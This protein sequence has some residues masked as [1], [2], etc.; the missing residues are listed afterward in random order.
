M[1][2]G[3]LPSSSSSSSAS[4]PSSSSLPS[5][6]LPSFGSPLST[7]PSLADSP[8]A[9]PGSL[10]LEIPQNDLYPHNTSPPQNN[11]NSSQQQQQQQ[12][13]A[14]WRFCRVLI[15]EFTFNDEPYPDPNPP[16]TYPLSTNPSSTTPGTGSSPGTGANEAI[17]LTVVKPIP[18]TGPTPITNP[19]PSSN[20]TPVEASSSSPSRN[21][22]LGSVL[23]S[24]LGQGLGPRSPGA[25]GQGL[26]SPGAQRQGPSSPGAS[27]QGPRS[28]SASGQGLGSPGKLTRLVKRYD[29]KGNVKEVE[30]EVDDDGHTKDK[31]RIGEE[32]RCY[33]DV[34]FISQVVPQI[35]LGELYSRYDAAMT[36]LQA[37]ASYVPSAQG[38][39]LGTPRGSRPP[40]PARLR[41]GAS[42]G[43]TLINP[44]HPVNTFYQHPVNTPCQYILSTHPI[45]TSYRVLINTLINISY[46]YILSTHPINTS[47]QYIL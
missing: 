19:H 35:S 26:G 33:W 28:P 5:S 23:G 6:S 7:H 29:S 11:S 30:E 8:G 20:F 43:N 15:F 3:A 21:K 4:P 45:N 14:V 27:G 42:P 16:S 31:G 38:Q 1:P 18:S 44:P 22:G 37:S 24:V 40:S 25:S 41:G 2:K 34:K 13:S 36:P 39:G 46:Q 32:W 9:S 47:Y 10:S 12:R 17:T